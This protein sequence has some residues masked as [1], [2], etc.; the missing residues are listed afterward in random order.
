[1]FL[2]WCCWCWIAEDQGSCDNFLKSGNNENCF[3]S[4]LFLPQ[5]ISWKH[6]MRFD[7]ILPTEDPFENSSNSCETLMCFINLCYNFLN[8]FLTSQWCSHSSPRMIPCQETT[9]LIYL[10]DATPHLL[11]VCHVIAAIQSRLQVALGFLL[12][13]LF[14]S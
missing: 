2:A 10:Q 11:E 13:L 5:Q 1:M 4:G 14:L 6:V 8:S 3:I 7:G 12:L 9:F